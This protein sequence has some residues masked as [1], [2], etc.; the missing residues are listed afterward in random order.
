VDVPLQDQGLWVALLL[1]LRKAEETAAGPA[2]GDDGAEAAPGDN[3]WLQLAS[4]L[5]G[6]VRNGLL[7][8]WF[9]CGG[10]A[11]HSLALSFGVYSGGGAGCGDWLMGVAVVYVQ[12]HA[13]AWPLTKH[14]EFARQ[15]DIT[16]N[17]HLNTL[18]Y[19]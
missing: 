6:K 15:A 14:L 7:G 5:C 4:A 2:A 1:L 10:C 12:W 16:V 17:D 8:W 18:F 19:F 11:P 13:L 9:A 3:W